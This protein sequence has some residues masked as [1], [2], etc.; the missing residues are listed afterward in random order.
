MSTPH[1]K[2]AGIMG[3]RPAREGNVTQRVN[4]KEEFLERYRPV[5][6]PGL[7][8]YAQLRE[9]LMAAIDA[10]HWAPGSRIP[11][12]AALASMTPYSLGTVQ[13]AMRDLVQSGVVVRRRGEGTFVATT[14]RASMSSPLHLRFETGAGRVLAVYPRIVARE[15]VTDTGPWTEVFRGEP[16]DLLRIDRVFS[17]GKLFQVFSSIYLDEARFPLFSERLAPSL[18]AKNFKEV[19]RREYN[20]AIQR[21]QQYL[22][23]EEMPPAVCKALGLARGS[24]GTRLQL[25]AIGGGGRPVY[26]QDAYIPPNGCRLRLSDWTPGL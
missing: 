13:K 15:R 12:E 4:S 20:I 21:I 1:A 23:V 7:P 25:T 9:T 3:S 10:G 16:A 19:L 26:Y 17:V 8:R 14:R 18:Q 11:N 24:V 2:I 5:D 22:R 6:I